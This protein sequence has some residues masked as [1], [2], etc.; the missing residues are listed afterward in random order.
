M[1]QNLKLYPYFQAC[2]SLH[3]WLPVFFLYFVSILSV[4]EV[5]VL[6]AIYYWAVVTLEVPSGYFSDRIGRRPTLLIA[7]AAWTVAYLLFA[8]S[9]TFTSFAIAQILLAVGMAF[10]SGTDSSLLYDSLKAADRVEEIGFFEALGQ[11]YGFYATA[12]A[13]LTGGILS[14]ID[15]RFA[16]GLSA[17]GSILAVRIAWRMTEPPRPHKESEMGFANQLLHCVKRLKNR[18][19][20]WIFMFVLS[21]TVFNHV[22]YEFFQPYLDLVMQQ[23]GLGSNHGYEITPVVTSLHV[24][25]TM[26]VAGWGSRRAILLQQKLG[27]KGAL[28]ATLLLQAILMG[29][30]S[31]I[32]HPVVA[33]LLL[34]RSIP[35]ALMTPIINATVHPRL[36]SG[37][38]ATFL[39][40]QSFAGRICFGTALLISSTFTDEVQCLT[41]ETLSSILMAY[42]L[43]SGVVF[44]GLAT[45][46]ISSPSKPDEKP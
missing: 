12:F 2:A 11:S 19:L 15:L 1:N 42:T 8:S 22:P 20:L 4:R 23:T 25:L 44:I 31:W 3:F 9:Q 24:A 33:A 37:L 46:N 38:R 14:G 32:V 26:M 34:F 45:L 21:I 39:S 29:L 6:E 43:A 16:Y 13:A 35:R 18:T 40:L 17:I 41:G 10:R 30:M 36:N 27:V 5:L 7:G 28:L